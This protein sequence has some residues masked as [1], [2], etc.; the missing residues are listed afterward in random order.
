MRALLLNDTQAFAGIERH[1]LALASALPSEHVH[2]TIACPHDSQLAKRAVAAHI[3]HKPIAMR[4]LHDVYS[5]LRIRSYLASRDADLVHAHN[6]TT[7]F[8]AAVAAH[9]GGS[10]PCIF[11]QHFLEPAH[12]SR[13][14]PL[15]AFYRLAH[16]WVNQHTS[17]FIVVS[18]AARREMIARGD[19]PECR[20][21]VVP[22]GVPTPDADALAPAAAIRAELGIAQDALLVVCAARLEPEKDIQVLVE[23][24]TAVARHL[25]N[26]RCVIAGEGSQRRE[27]EQRIARNGANDSVRILGFRADVQAVIRAADVFALPS[28]A[29]SFGLV[30]LEAMALGRPVIA[31]RSGGPVEIVDDNATGILVPPSSPEPLAE[32]ILRLFRE[33]DTRAEMGRC[34]LSRYRDRFTAERMAR[35]TCR[36][37]S[38]AIRE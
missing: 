37:Y 11:T 4:G 20:I 16:R 38:R 19:A 1:I 6:G 8:V 7:A 28:R 29:E 27:I 12:R 23:A 30:L 14:S 9:L 36:V 17:H 2:A 3:P 21:T 33:P 26:A 34:G 31:V 5:G 15:A 13:R 35:D 24:M 32:A 25:P 22:N 18:D 10:A